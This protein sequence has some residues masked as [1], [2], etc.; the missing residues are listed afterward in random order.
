MNSATNCDA[1]TGSRPTLRYVRDTYVMGF[2]GPPALAAPPPLLLPPP[3]PAAKP[4]AAAAAENAELPL[5]TL[6]TE[7]R[8]WCGDSGANEPKR[9][10]KAGDAG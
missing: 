2:G 1:D 3:L 5:L 8:E 10:P 9:L 4:L 7:A 6:D